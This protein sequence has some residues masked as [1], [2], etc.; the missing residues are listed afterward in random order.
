VQLKSGSLSKQDSCNI[1]Y[2]F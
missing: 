2:I 1:C